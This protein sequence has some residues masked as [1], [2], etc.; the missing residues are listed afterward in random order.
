MGQNDSLDDILE[1]I[2]DFGVVQVVA[3][4]VVCLNVLINSATHVAYVFTALDS[5]FRCLV[6]ECD[7]SSPKY[8][9]W[10]LSNAVPFDD[11]NKPERCSM[12]AHVNTSGVDNCTAN[13]FDIN[14]IVKCNSYVFQNDEHY[15]GRE[16]N[17]LCNDSK[18][19]LTLV[20]TLNTVGMFFGLLIT[21]VI[22]DKY[23]RKF[24][25]L[26]GIS[27]CGVV[28]VI[29]A[30]SPT[31]EWFCFFEFL[32]AVLAAGSY[33]CGFIL[34]VELVTPK[35]RALTGCISC[36]CYALGE[37]VIAAVAWAVMDWK[38]IL[39]LVYGPSIFVIFLWWTI[40]ESIRWYLSKGRIEEPKKILRRFAQANGKQISEESL[41]KLKLILKEQQELH[42]S[43]SFLD[44]LKSMPLFLR[45]LNCSFCWV[46]CAFLF[47]GMTLNSVTLS[48][49]SYL[50]FI[51]IS[52]TE[53]PAYCCSVYIANRIGRKYS[54][55]LSYAL[56]AVSCFAFIF[57]NKDTGWLH[58]LVY[59]LGKFGATSAFI[60]IYVMASE[61]FPTSLRH[62]TMGVCSMIGR[63]G[64]VAS[65]QIP[66]LS[67]L[68]KPLPLVLF[69]SL[70]A[71]SALSSLLFPETLNLKLPDTI[72]EAERI[73][74]KSTNN[75]Q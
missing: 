16:F 26:V 66:L 8:D 57:V 14:H 37:V 31:F 40:P 13:A 75:E 36:C 24:V 34:G 19:K 12:Y 59:C 43:V 5:N 7:G 45:F 62:T 44:M 50:D 20:G 61:V 73:G 18:W 4:L 33:G 32:E 10:W 28:G 38:M 25:L 3:L 27:S 11:D 23:G 67:D 65:P 52:L 30:F 54:M 49:N 29:K 1:E 64:S 74:S 17:M 55:S 35:K 46:T 6:P 68:W 9:P 71:V 48:S 53:I 60:L 56:T 70:A 42:E 21:G 72:K 39:Y 47:Y 41:D 2:G 58:I 15:L 51:Y 63:L 69:T 22:S